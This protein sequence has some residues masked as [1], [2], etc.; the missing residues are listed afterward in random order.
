MNSLLFVTGILLTPA[1]LFLIVCLAIA[2]TYAGVLYFTIFRELIRILFIK[3]SNEISITVS[4]TEYKFIKISDGVYIGEI[5]VIQRLYIAIIGANPS[6]YVDMNAPVHNVS[7]YDAERFCQM[8]TARHRYNFDLP[9]VSEW[10][11][12]LGS[13]P[14]IQTFSVS[15]SGVPPVKQ[16]QP[17]S[18]GFYDLLGTVWEWTKTNSTEY[19]CYAFVCG[20]SWR[21]TGV[22]FPIIKS[23][24]FRG[25]MHVNTCDDNTG[26]RVVI[27]L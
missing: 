11:R 19:D 15:K 24:S 27:R 13:D 25:V 2:I 1:V 22:P 10:R 12:A 7:L 26:F 17:N 16:R 23:N 8:L 14:D 9:T 4:Q 6:R 18:L 5:P 21:N 3:R 20:G